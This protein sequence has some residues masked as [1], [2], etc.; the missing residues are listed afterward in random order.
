MREKDRGLIIDPFKEAL[1]NL[2][3]TE[4][5][6]PLRPEMI[7]VASLRRRLAEAGFN[8]EIGVNL[9]GLLTPTKFRNYTGGKGM[10]VAEIVCGDRVDVLETKLLELSKGGPG[11]VSNQTDEVRQGSETRGLRQFVARLF[12]VALE[13]VSP[14]DF[15]DATNRAVWKGLRR[16]ASDERKTQLAEIFAGTSEP[17]PTTASIPVGS[18]DKVFEF[19][20]SGLKEV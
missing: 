12:G 15:C 17:K 7:D 3:S 13:V 16:G 19:L 10:A 20:M 4:N 2:S 1:E 11:I 8:M 5:P 14:E 18:V 6:V 9:K